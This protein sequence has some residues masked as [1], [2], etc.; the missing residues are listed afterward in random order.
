M[1]NMTSLL[2]SNGFDLTKISIK[3]ND[4]ITSK[5]EKDEKHAF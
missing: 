4:K 5:C 2:T 3:I 1:F